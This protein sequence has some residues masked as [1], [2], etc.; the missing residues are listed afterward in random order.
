[1]VG[2]RLVT[3]DVHESWH[4]PV[5]HEV[6]LVLWGGYGD[7]PTMSIT[8]VP[9]EVG[10]RYLMFARWDA[11]GELWA[12]SCDHSTRYEYAKE[13]LTFLH[14]LRDPARGGRV[15]GDVAL[16]AHEFA[17]DSRRPANTAITLIGSG[18]TRTVTPLDGKY[19]FTGLPGGEYSVAAT[20]I[21]SLIGHDS[22]IVRLPGDGSCAKTDFYFHPATSITGTIVDDVGNS[23]SASVDVAPAETWAT[24]RFRATSS[25]TKADGVFRFQSLPPGEYVVAVNLRD[26]LSYSDYPRTVYPSDDA[27]KVL[28]LDAGQH[29]D[30]GTWMIGAPLKPVVMR[31]RLVDP[32]GAP[33]RKQG[34]DLFDVTRPDKPDD[35]PHVLGHATDA[36]GWVE[37]SGKSTRRYA[38]GRSTEWSDEI[39]P[40]SK[41]FAAEEATKGLTVVVYDK[42][43]RRKR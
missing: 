28:R 10:Q 32:S 5:G 25:Y 22:R 36:N 42:Q 26:T 13:A 21:Q 14:S 11:N 18:L 43:G 7:E 38:I 12:H 40:L 34:I 2:S 37:Y 41:P 30:L 20:P 15:Y 19:E 4:G 31:L 33:L 6:R 35:P 8:P 24:D 3:Y 39:V 27:P 1:M 17:R 16:S 9:A 23:V 29:I